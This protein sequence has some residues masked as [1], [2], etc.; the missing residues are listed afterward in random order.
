[1]NSLLCCAGGYRPTNDL[2]VEEGGRREGASAADGVHADSVPA[3]QQVPLRREGHRRAQE[4]RRLLRAADHRTL[5]NKRGTTGK[6]EKRNEE[7]KRS[8]LDVFDCLEITACSG[9]LLSLKVTS[10]C[11]VVDKE[12]RRKRCG[13]RQTEESTG[14]QSIVVR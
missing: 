14:H 10:R 8:I 1:M 9:A 2:A 3:R 13:R 12:E 4:G 6:K 5:L 7:E 11:G